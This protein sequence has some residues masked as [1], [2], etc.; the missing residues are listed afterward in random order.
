MILLANEATAGSHN[1]NTPTDLYLIYAI[2]IGYTCQPG[3]SWSGVQV[4]CPTNVA[5]PSQW[6]ESRQRLCLGDTTKSP[7]G[8][9]CYLLI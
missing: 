1:E 6:Q 5:P 4:T 8:P 3:D 9:L 2:R 7:Q